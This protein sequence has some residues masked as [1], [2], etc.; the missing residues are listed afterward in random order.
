MD[1][2]SSGSTS[3]YTC[4]AEPYSFM[5]KHANVTVTEERRESMSE[6]VKV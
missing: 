6:G 5:P 4:S 2:R 1:A 3:S